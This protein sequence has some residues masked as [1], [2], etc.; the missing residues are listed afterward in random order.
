M[1]ASHAPNPQPWVDPF[2]AV[3]TGN[4]HGHTIG[5]TG[6]RR[7]CTHAEASVPLE[8]APNGVRRGRLRVDDP[9]RQQAKP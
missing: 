1:T 9:R 5:C 2:P 4:N 3:H 6:L 7:P 8:T